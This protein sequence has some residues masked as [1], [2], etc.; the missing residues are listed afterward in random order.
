MA[1]ERVAVR[2]SER[3]TAPG[4]NAVGVVNP[5]DDVNVT[6]VI[7]RRTQELPRRGSRPVPR[8]K[9]AEL[10]GAN[11]AD[12]EQI[13]Q[14]AAEHDLTVSQVDLARRSIRLS[15]TVADMNEAFGTELRLFQSPDGLY[16]GRTGELS[17]PS[18]LGDL[19]LIHISEPTRP[20]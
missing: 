10:Y 9:F 6:V 11:P 7:R 13:E 5:N 3:I 20:Y 19:S 15:G 8:E 1:N 4:S 2:G 14:F 12:V 17:V 18:N 16:R